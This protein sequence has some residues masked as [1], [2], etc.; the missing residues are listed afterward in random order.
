MSKLSNHSRWYSKSSPNLHSVPDC[1]TNFAISILVLAMDLWL[2][3][4]FAS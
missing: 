4:L 3:V 2:Q 1:I